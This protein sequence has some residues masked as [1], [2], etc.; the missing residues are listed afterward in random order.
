M[1]KVLLMTLS[2]LLAIPNF[3]DRDLSEHPVYNKVE[4]FSPSLSTIN[5]VDKLERY[6]DMLAVQKNIPIP[7]VEYCILLENTVSQRFYHGFSHYKLN[8]N[9]IAAVIQLPGTGTSCKVQPN[10]ILKNENAACSQQALVMMEVLT[11]KKISYRKIGFPH[12]FAMEANIDGGWY[13]LDANM[14]P[15]ISVSARNHEN[16]KGSGDR[17]KQFYEPSRHNSMD[18]QFGH[19]KFATIGAVNAEAAPRLKIF[20]SITAMLSK[21]LWLLPL[22]VLY[23]KREKGREYVF[24]YIE[25]RDLRPLYG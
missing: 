24:P 5:T 2:V 20:Q 19:N 10:D 17:L 11:R 3:I 16:W 9:W 25:Q 8:E 23:W 6:V 18:Y 4:K 15:E 22:V 7:S 21:L 13:F 1:V 14:E 12:H